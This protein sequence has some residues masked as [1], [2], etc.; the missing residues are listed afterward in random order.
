M[1]PRATVAVRVDPADRSRIRLSLGEALAAP[2]V[3]VGEGL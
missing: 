1:L 3:A 2:L